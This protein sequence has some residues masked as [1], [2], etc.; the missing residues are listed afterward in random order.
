MQGIKFELEGKITTNYGGY[1]QLTRFYHFCLGHPPK[2][3]FDLDFTNVEWIDGNLCA[4]LGAIVFHLS[5]NHGHTVSTDTLVIKER[6]DVLFRNGFLKTDEPIIDDRESTVPFSAFQ[7]SNKEGFCSYVDNQLLKHRG[8]PSSLT[9]NLKEK[10]SEDLLEVFCNT[11]HHANTSDPFFVGGQ[12]YPRTGILKFTM[13][14]LGDG[15][16]PRINKATQGNIGNNLDAI[17]WALA[18]NSTKKVLENC[19]GGLGIKGMYK[20]CQES[21]GV[22]QIISGDGYWSSELENTIFQGGRELPTPFLGTTINLF[23]K[24]D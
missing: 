9:D 14:D 22:I 19:P 6:F 13:V 12:Y 11:N 17:L 7:P 23:F 16:L 10:I 20:Y 21:G 2:S 24:K 15:F 4:F 1:N 8:M 3:H 5:K 18:G